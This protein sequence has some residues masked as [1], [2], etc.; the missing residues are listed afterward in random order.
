VTTTCLTMSDTI[1]EIQAHYK[2]LPS[3]FTI[4]LYAELGLPLEPVVLQVAVPPIPSSISAWT[5]LDA[6]N[7]LCHH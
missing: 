4:F 3:P 5:K 7:G 6:S 2:N 1:R